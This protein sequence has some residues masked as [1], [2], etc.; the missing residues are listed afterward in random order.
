MKKW[1]ETTRG[2][3]KVRI[4]AQDGGG[5]YPIHGAI[6]EGGRWKQGMWKANGRFTVHEADNPDD[7]ILDLSLIHI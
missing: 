7:L 3:S 4:Y 2:G 6:F 5:K 1:K